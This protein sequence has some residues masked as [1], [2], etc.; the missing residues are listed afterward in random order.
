MKVKIRKQD[1]EKTAFERSAEA[2]QHNDR[3]FKEARTMI[4]STATRPTARRQDGLFETDALRD[5]RVAEEKR[6]ADAKNPA[7]VK[8]VPA[9]LEVGDQIAIFE[10]FCARTGFHKTPWNTEMLSRCV[11]YNVGAGNLTF[12]SSGLDACYKFLSE[13]DYLES[14]VRHRG[15]GAPKEF[16][17]YVPQPEPVDINARRPLTQP[18]VKQE[19]SKEEHD[20][21]QNMPLDELGAFVR[22]GY[23]TKRHGESVR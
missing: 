4:E 20:R 10:S 2:R 1:Y 12:S 23:N 17:E 5:A 9:P 19:I 6:R 14:R 21:L 15:Q 11:D 16:P 3:L 8:P 13:G 22:K 18:S 7:P